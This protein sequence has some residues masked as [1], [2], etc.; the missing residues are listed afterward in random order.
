MKLLFILAE[1]HGLAKLRM[2]T[3]NTLAILRNTTVLLGDALRMFKD[4]TC[5]AF[6]TRELAREALARTRRS[7]NG[8]PANSG[9]R[10]K[11]LNL[12]TAKLHFLGDYAS[13]IPE[14]GTAESYST[15]TVSLPLI[16]NVT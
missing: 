6:S 1:W 15:E 12:N 14:Y 2:H 16:Y 8:D 9:R 13:T 5:S 4:K 11:T 3:E 7:T 10:G